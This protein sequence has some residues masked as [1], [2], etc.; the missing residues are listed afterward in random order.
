MN[1]DYI[2]AVLSMCG[3]RVFPFV[4]LI[5]S[6][7]L[8]LRVKSVPATMLFLGSLLICLAPYVFL[9]IGGTK[10]FTMSN[11][12]M[13]MASLLQCVG[14]LFYVLSVRKNKST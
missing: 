12:V 5:A 8:F 2:F 10:W 7:I 9:S 13:F 11:F 1:L 4:F 6:I 14:F 3:I